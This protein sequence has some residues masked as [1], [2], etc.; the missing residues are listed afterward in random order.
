MRDNWIDI[1]LVPLP[2]SGQ[3]IVSV[4]RL[5]GEPASFTGVVRCDESRPYG[6]DGDSY[7]YAADITHWQPLPEPKQLVI[8]V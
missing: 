8:T 5:W 2:V 4:T 7:L 1:K 3:V 6:S